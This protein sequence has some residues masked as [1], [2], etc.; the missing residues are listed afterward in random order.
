MGLGLD[1]ICGSSG[2]GFVT[3]SGDFL[4]LFGLDLDDLE[5]DISF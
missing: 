5:Y 1:A 4:V 2:N 3:N